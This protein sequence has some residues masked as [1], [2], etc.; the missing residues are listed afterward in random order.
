MNLMVKRGVVPGVPGTLVKLHVRVYIKKFQ[1]STWH[2]RHKWLEPNPGAGLRCVGFTRSPAQT[3]H[4]SG[5]G[6]KKPGF[7]RVP[8]LVLR[9]SPSAC[10]QVTRGGAI[11]VVI[12]GL[13]IFHP[14]ADRA[15]LPT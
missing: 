7:H 8:W 10:P 4:K 12:N 2:T 1:E 14:D 11:F 9:Q 5:T 6:Y 3:R 13:F 15:I